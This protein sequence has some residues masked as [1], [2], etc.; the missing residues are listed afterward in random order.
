M[1][2]IRLVF[3]VFCLGSIHGLPQDS[4]PSDLTENPIENPSSVDSKPSDLTEIVLFA[5]KLA[6][7]F[8][9]NQTNAAISGNDDW[10]STAF[11]EA[12]DAAFIY[13]YASLATHFAIVMQ[14]QGVTLHDIFF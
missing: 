13:T 10:N 6:L 3:V 8:I 11:W 1:A 9:W 7:E 14:N 4:K 5:V 2:W 12:F